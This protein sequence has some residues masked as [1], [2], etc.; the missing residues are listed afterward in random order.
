MD[1]AGR[2][3]ERHRTALRL[4]NL[5]VQSNLREEFEVEEYK[6]SEFPF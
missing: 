5:C 4:L 6:E 3:V 2:D 1:K